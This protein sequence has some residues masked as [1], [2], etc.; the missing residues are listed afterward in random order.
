MSKLSYSNQNIVESCD[1]SHEK[2]WLVVKQKIINVYGDVVF[3]SWFKSVHLSHHD[4]GTIFLTVS[5]RFIRDWIKTNYLDFMLK[6]WRDIDKKVINIDLIAGING[7]TQQGIQNKSQNHINYN[8]SNHNHQKNEVHKEQ[9]IVENHVISD[10]F[11]IIV[12]T[13]K[14]ENIAGDKA[15]SVKKNYN[16]EDIV[17]NLTIDFDDKAVRN[18]TKKEKIIKTNFFQK[19]LSLIND[20]PEENERRADKSQS[21]KNNDCLHFHENNALSGRA[22]QN[23][24]FDRRYTF[25]NFVTDDSNEL[26]FFAAKSIA[27]NV[28]ISRHHSNTNPLFLYGGVG[29]GK[30]HLIHAIANHKIQSLREIYP[31][32]WEKIASEKIVYSSS[33]RFMREFLAALRN[34]DTKSFKNKFRNVDILMIDDIQFL[35]GKGCTQEEFFHIFSGLMSDGKQLV[36]SADRV[37]S[38]LSGIEEKLKSRLGCGIIADIKKGDYDFRFNI[39]QKKALLFGCDF[40][41]EIL[42]LIAKNIKH[43]MREL[44]GALNNLVMMKNLNSKRVINVEFVR[45]KLADMI[46]SNREQNDDRKENIRDISANVVVEQKQS[47]LPAI[48]INRRQDKDY[49]LKIQSMVSNY[50]NISLEDLNSNKRTK[51]IVLP[52]QIAMYLAKKMTSETLAEIAKKFG[53]KNHSTIIHGISKVEQMMREDSSIYSDVEK[54]V[55]IIKNQ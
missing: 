54:I 11:S 16:F 22:E 39:L 47:S 38:A 49:I 51:N 29:L 26:A 13:N 31:N 35:N 21:Q 33:E 25:D 37:P 46:A 8:N 53:G 10:F 52:K 45:E 28:Q 17:E 24:Y 32:S 18:R 7:A 1:A 3:K 5:S 55:Q 6:S 20:V 4:S 50:Y 15:L 48:Q 34:R 43:S 30:T 2:T 27:D 42:R 19:S 9:P 14:K 40:D 23:L 41:D 36:I 12:D 44:E